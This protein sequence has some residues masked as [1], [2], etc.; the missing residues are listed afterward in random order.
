[1]ITL[2][3]WSERMGEDMVLR[4]FRATTQQSYETAVRQL[5]QWAKAEPEDLSEETVRDY[6]L[7]LREEKK[8]DF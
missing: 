8:A 3:N 2:D 4:D 7:Y 5:L 1:M 6:F